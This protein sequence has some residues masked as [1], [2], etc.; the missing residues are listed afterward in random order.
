MVSTTGLISVSAIDSLKGCSLGV[1]GH[2]TPATRVAKAW[3]ARHNAAVARGETGGSPLAER[4]M[5]DDPAT[6]SLSPEEIRRYSRHLVLP[7]VGMEGQLR[8]RESSV[9]LVGVGGLGS[10]AA[11][12]LAAAGVGRI[13]LVDDDCV[14][15]SNLQRQVLY[16]GGDLGRPKVEAARERLGQLNPNVRVERHTE[17][18]DAGN[19]RRLVRDYDVVLDGA[20]NFPT[21]YLV[22]DACALAGK[23][24]VHASVYRF[25]GQLSVFHAGHGPCYRCLYPEPP[26][27]GAVP[28]CAE[29][30]VLGVLP[31]ILGSLQ[32]AET[33]KLLLGGGESMRGRLLILN[34]LEMRFRE[35]ALRADPDCPLCGARPTLRTVEAS[36][37]SCAPAPMAGPAEGFD[38][39]PREL[40]RRLDEG[41]APLLLDVRTPVEWE[42]CRL[43]GARL[44]PLH[45][46]SG[47]LDELD[48]DAEIVVYCHVGLRS[49][50]AAAL[51]RGHGFRRVHNLTGG[52]L[53]WAREVDLEMP[54]Y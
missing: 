37:E 2:H 5:P 8:L 10:P 32:A 49:A 21:R 9:L 1:P 12:Y 46:L 48:P 16:G 42:I 6:P 26:P 18:F 30:G 29:G 28:S 53:A 50:M 27:P 45:E 33:V 22:N 34:A 39:G 54:R 4:K 44:L 20:D 13:G 14:E 7:E 31:G 41:A 11:L 47:R 15:E 24:D 36:A 40:R 38:L 25:E 51:L 3:P 43:D 35:M 52:I 19:A 17:R 23:P